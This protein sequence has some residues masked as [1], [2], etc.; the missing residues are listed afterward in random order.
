ML[1]MPSATAPS[2]GVVI[3]RGQARAFAFEGGQWLLEQALRVDVGV[4]R[5]VS[6]SADLS[7]FQ[8]FLDSPRAS[9]GEFG[10]GDLECAIEFRS[11]SKNA[12]FTGTRCAFTVVPRGLMG[13]ANCGDDVELW[14]LWNRRQSTKFNGVSYIVQR[15]AEAVYSPEGQAQ[16]RDLIS[17]YM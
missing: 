12:G 8:G 16:V 3:P 13:K 4:A 14:G 17:F 2:P 10:L 11:F 5:D 9:D 6:M 7:L 1:N 15:G